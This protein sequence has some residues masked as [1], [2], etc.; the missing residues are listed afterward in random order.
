MM[1]ELSESGMQSLLR[2]QIVGRIG[3][4]ADG[5]IYVV[6]INYAYDNDNV[7]GQT[8][9]GMK[10]RMMRRCPNV[11]FEVDQV[12]DV[13]TWQSVIA[14]GSYEELRDEQAS[15]AMNRLVARL[16]PI[17]ATGRAAQRYHLTAESIREAYTAGKGEPIVFRIHLERKTGRFEE[18]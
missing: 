17:V 7:Y 15:D 5:V 12:D 6:P 10:V 18:P 2:R 3:C 9:E 11:C 4:Q 8:A 16:M 1:G 14:W 13:G